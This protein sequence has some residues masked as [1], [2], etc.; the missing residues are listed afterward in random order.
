[1]F[2]SRD[3]DLLRPDVAENCRALIALAKLEGREV[4]VT[5]TVRDE[6]Y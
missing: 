5:E 1:M 2:K 4:L 6:E 3:I